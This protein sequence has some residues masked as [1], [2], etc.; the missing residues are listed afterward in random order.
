M[1]RL[2][3]NNSPFTV[4]ILFIFALLVKFRVLLH[5][6]EPVQVRGHII[7]NAIVEGM[8]FIF[9]HGGFAYGMIAIVILFI[10][11]LYLNSIAAR[12]KLFP[13]ST[14]IP[15]FVYLL[16]TS[17]HPSLSAFSETMLIN[18]LLLAV[19]VV[20]Q[21]L[22]VWVL[23]TLGPY[24]T[25]RIISVPG[26]PLVRRGPYRLFRPPNYMVVAGE[27]LVLPLVFGEVWIAIAF[28]LANAALL[29]WR[30]RQEETGLTPR[31]QSA[32]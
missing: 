32:A 2:F 10:Q 28:S 17:V 15:A 27:I 31:R 11:A 14:Y 18:W 8:F 3:K 7:Y 4:I 22:R 30:I 19:F 25:T 5:P 26:A 20:L 9:R 1:L 29:A 23:A 13:R 6:I 21:G 12:H 24:W 16:L